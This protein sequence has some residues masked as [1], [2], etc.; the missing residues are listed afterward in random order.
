MPIFEFLDVRAQVGSSRARAFHL[1]TRV[2]R[3]ESRVTVIVGL[4]LVTATAIQ[5]TNIDDLLAWEDLSIG[6]I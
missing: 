3:Q 5:L 2:V 6:G 4:E 1:R